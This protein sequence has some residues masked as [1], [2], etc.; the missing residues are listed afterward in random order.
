MGTTLQIALFALVPAWMLFAGSALLFSR[1]KTVAS[2]L[3]L[4]GA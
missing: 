3:Q 1:T 4:F 2:F